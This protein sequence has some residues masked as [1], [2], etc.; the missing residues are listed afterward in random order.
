MRLVP[1]DLVALEWE[2]HIHGDSRLTVPPS[3]ALSFN[4]PMFRLE[5]R[6]RRLGQWQQERLALNK[7]R[8]TSKRQLSWRRQFPREDDHYVPAMPPLRA[9]SR[10]SVNGRQTFPSIVC[11]AHARN[12]R[13]GLGRAGQ[14]LSL[15]W[16]PGSMA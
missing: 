10:P 3:K 7:Y 16:R 4:I 5:A 2:R 14:L 8:A 12:R 9:S 13:I 15:N 6:N 11:C 1:M